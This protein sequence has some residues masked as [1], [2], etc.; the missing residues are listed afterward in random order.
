MTG[1]LRMSSVLMSSVLMTS[2]LMT[3]VLRRRSVADASGYDQ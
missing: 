3:S 2:V 1:V